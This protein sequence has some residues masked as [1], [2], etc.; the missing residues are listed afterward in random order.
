M[1]KNNFQNEETAKD[2]EEAVL[3]IQKN[4]ANT[5]NQHV[6]NNTLTSIHG[7]YKVKPRNTEKIT[8]RKIEQLLSYCGWRQKSQKA[9]TGVIFRRK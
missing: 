9:K 2:K 4:L 6:K 1:N 3:P 8:R 7:K 5:I